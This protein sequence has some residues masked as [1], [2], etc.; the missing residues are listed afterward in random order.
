MSAGPARAGAGPN[1]AL[2]LGALLVA[3]VAGLAVFG[4][5]LAPADPLR[6]NYI[7]FLQQGFLK[8][9][10]A[11]GLAP[12]FPLGAD[13]FGRDVLS[14]LLWAVGPSLT[15]A[16]T[17]GALRLAVGLA[18]GLASGWSSAGLGRVMNA[19]TGLALT[20]PVLFVALLVIAAAGPRL[21]VAAFILGLAATGWAESARL[22]GERTRLVAQERYVEAARALGAS[23]AQI[24]GRHVLPQLLPLVWVLLAVEASSVLL[25][26][27]GLGLLGYFVNAVWLPGD[28]D[29]V[30][31]R[32]AGRPEL[33]QML[34]FSAGTRQPWSALAAGGLVLVTV[35]GLNLLGAGLPQALDPGRRPG[36][37]RRRLDRWSASLGDRIF[38]ALAEWQRTAATTAAVLALSGMIA[39]GGWWLW[40]QSRPAASRAAALPVPGNHLWAAARHDSAGTLYSPAPGPSSGGLAWTFDDPDGVFPPVAAA[41]GTLYLVTGAA[42]GTLTALSPDGAVLWQAPIPEA[43]FGPSPETYARPALRLNASTPAL[44]A[45]GDILVVTGQGSVQAFTPEGQLRWRWAN[46]RPQP[47]L[48][49]PVIGADGRV[50]FAT[51]ADVIALSP[52]GQRLWRVD[53]PTYSYTLPAL[54]LSPDGRWLIFQD[55]LL[56]AADGAQLLSAPESIDLFLFG[57]DGK[58]YLRLQTELQSWEVSETE[59]V[60]RPQIRL[61]QRGLGL[62]FGLAADAGVTPDGW[63]WFAYGAASGGS[64]KIVWSDPAGQQ[65]AVVNSPRSG[66]Q[67]LGVDPDRRL[68]VCDALPAAPPGCSALSADGA[69]V[70]QADLAEGRGFVIGAALAPGRLYAASS[71]GRLYALGAAAP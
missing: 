11:P 53:L 35:L 47:W 13:E 23:D 33:G 18:V 4:P 51:E 56:R 31:V 52:D 1:W 66:A 5:A 57:A 32:A 21:G 48:S 64:V 8:P 45:G 43:E 65:V 54:R 40:S 10:F 42:G 26:T 68:Y 19:V 36:W 37:L 69:L 29:F 58:T 16:L 30:S 27:A 12:G 59:A 7:V 71:G 70:W 67:V 50:Y 25:T 60:I 17:A 24:L 20:V 34:A 41:D 39:G 6:E 46:P 22:I 2:W 38:L 49:N 55:A 61:D 9:P 14:R 63:A 28:G 15:L 62:G 3:G 44:S